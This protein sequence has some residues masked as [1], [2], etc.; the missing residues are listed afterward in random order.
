MPYGW[1]DD[2][3][4]TGHAGMVPLLL[5]RN[6][7]GGVADDSWLSDGFNLLFGALIEWQQ[8]EFYTYQE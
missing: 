8:T 3:G 2:L 5:D 6:P 1:L 7:E 4:V